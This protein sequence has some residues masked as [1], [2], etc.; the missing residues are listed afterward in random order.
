MEKTETCPVSTALKYVGKKWSIEII[1]NMF[2]G[3]KS[4]TEFLQINPQLSGK[5]LSQRLKELEANGIITKDIT[6]KSPLKIEYNLTQKGQKL[7]RVI[8]ELA[9]FAM[10]TCPKELPKEQCKLEAIE[11]LKNTLKV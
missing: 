2:F 7:N 6:C 1:K 8:F 5:V 10:Q 3:T 11:N 4:F 9:V